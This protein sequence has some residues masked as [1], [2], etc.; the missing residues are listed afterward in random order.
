ML[1]Y[2]KMARRKNQPDAVRAKFELAERLRAIRTELYGERGGPELARR[3][4]IPV[5]TWYNYESGVTVPSELMLRFIELASVEPIWLLRGT[6][7]RYRSLPPSFDTEGGEPSVQSLLRM[8][9]QYLEGPKTPARSAFGLPPRK[10]EKLQQA[11]EPDESEAEGDSDAIA[12]TGEQSLPQLARAVAD[13]GW[14]STHK[15]GGLVRA[16]GNAMVPIIAD[17]AFVAYAEEEES[18]AA[19]EGRLVVS[20]VQGRPIVRWFEQ[21]G[22]YV[23]LRAENPAFEP[24]MTLLD[25]N[26]QPNDRR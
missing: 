17:G 6:G 23:L 12:A 4:G 26:A 24:A 7:P 3:L 25:L 11:D 16:E 20:W 21:S 18:P 19:L 15:T 1:I 13:Y 22:Q 5:R 9:L 2:A 14:M 8:A 10:E